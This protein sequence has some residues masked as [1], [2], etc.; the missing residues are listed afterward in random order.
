MRKKLILSAKVFR[1]IKKNLLGL[2][3]ELQ[4]FLAFH[5]KC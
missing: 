5:N 1:N 2:I 4:L 3:F